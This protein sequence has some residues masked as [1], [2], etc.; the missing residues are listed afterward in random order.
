MKYRLD[1]PSN[2]KLSDTDQRSFY[3]VWDTIERYDGRTSTP[4]P[5]HLLVS[6]SAAPATPLIVAAQ[7]AG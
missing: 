6:Q 1:F 7:P 5:D 2:P 4:T 3:E